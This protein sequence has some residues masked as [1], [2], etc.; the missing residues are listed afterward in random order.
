MRLLGWLPVMRPL[1]R[2]VLGFALL[3]RPKPRM[4]PPLENLASWRGSW[5]GDTILQVLSRGTLNGKGGIA[6]A[7]C[8]WPRSTAYLQSSIASL[9]CLVSRIFRSGLLL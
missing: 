8:P 2:G 9:M 4:P 5:E 1:G 3:L 6:G 7:A